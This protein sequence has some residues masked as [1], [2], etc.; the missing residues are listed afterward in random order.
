MAGPMTPE[1]WEK[2]SE[3]LEQAC[4]LPPHER[5]AF[6]EQ[7][8]GQDRD[9]LH[10]AR[11]LVRQ[12][13]GSEFL[14]KA[15][16]GAPA[17]LVISHARLPVG[18]VLAE[19]FEIR[20]EPNPGGIGD[21][22]QAFDRVAQEVRAVELL[23]P[24]LAG[25]ESRV[26]HLRKEVQLRRQITH[27]NLCRVY[28]VVL[29]RM[30]SGEPAL[31]LVMQWLEGRTLSARLMRGVLRFEEA[32]PL[33]EEIAAGLAAAHT[34]GLMHP[35]VKPAN[36]MLTGGSER[37]HAVITDF[38]GGIGPEGAQGVDV[39]AAAEIHSFGVLLAEMVGIDP[40][41][42][43]QPTDAIA[44][45]W[46]SVIRKCV[47]PQPNSR[48]VSAQEACRALRQEPDRYS[49]RRRVVLGAIA[50][51]AASAAAWLGWSIVTSEK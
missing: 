46:M 16:P 47:S 39:D 22:Y 4:E 49:L 48:Y 35:C 12:Q 17:R 44:R 31:F 43:V 13:P 41:D 9:V 23:P 2:V 24:E 36:I 27:P 29:G 45:R 10:W 51:A 33:V 20:S 21:V 37:S 42:P 25:D 5:E 11:K 30:P 18:F 26:A 7:A 50:A 8:C 32:L 14:D 34:A 6:L 40:E 3:V 1:R 38:G 15:V 19:R 28:D